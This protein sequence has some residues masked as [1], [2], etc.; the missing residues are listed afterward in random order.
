MRK[1]RWTLLYSFN[2]HQFNEL[3]IKEFNNHCIEKKTILSNAGNLL[4]VMMNMKFH[5][6]W[7]YYIFFEKFLFILSSLLK[8]SANKN[9]FSFCIKKNQFVDCS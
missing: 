1:D 6:R 4:P 8:F 3:F 9:N 5:Y 2:I 7:I